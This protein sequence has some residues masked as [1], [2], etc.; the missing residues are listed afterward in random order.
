MLQLVGD[1]E[2]A[3]SSYGFPPN[4]LH[5]EK[6]NY[7]IRI[8]E[9]GYL[10]MFKNG[11]QIQKQKISKYHGD[12]GFTTQQDITGKLTVFNTGEN[13]LHLSVFPNPSRE[14]I[15]YFYAQN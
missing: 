6:A 14:K 3:Y 1:Y 4:Y 7:G 9:E 13:I 11:K 12:H 5:D 15:N 8:T 10:F 2:W